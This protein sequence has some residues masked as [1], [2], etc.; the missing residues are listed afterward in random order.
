MCCILLVLAFI[1][2]GFFFGFLS[3]MFF[4]MDRAFQ[5]DMER[6]KYEYAK[7]NASTCII[8]EV[9]TPAL[10]TNCCAS[11]GC[12]ACPENATSLT[13]DVLRVFYDAANLSVLGWVKMDDIPL[14]KGAE[15][16]V[17]H[18]A[19]QEWKAYPDE[20]VCRAG[21]TIL[22]LPGCETRCRYQG[23]AAVE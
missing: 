17:E 15:Q 4:V 10:A 9:P 7:A 13:D 16:S 12:I 11:N 8:P 6:M 3:I 20:A 14:T 2:L 19:N 23:D 1:P 18:L 5:L 21:K 22:E